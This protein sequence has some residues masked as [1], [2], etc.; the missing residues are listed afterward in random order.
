MGRTPHLNLMQR[1][2]LYLEL[3]IIFGKN[4]ENFLK[5]LFVSL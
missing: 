4:F 1:Y 2:E 5:K 3:Q